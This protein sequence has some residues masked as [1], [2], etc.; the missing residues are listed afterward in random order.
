[1]SRDITTHPSPLMVAMR[2]RSTFLSLPTEVRRLIYSF[3]NEPLT[4]HLHCTAPTGSGKRVKFHCRA[5]L[6]RDNSKPRSLSPALLVTVPRV[7][8]QLQVEIQHEFGDEDLD[9]ETIIG[10]S[11]MYFE[12][13]FDM[14]KFGEERVHLMGL[15]KRLRVCIDGVDGR[16]RLEPEE[17]K[18]FG[19]HR[20][21]VAEYFYGGPRMHGDDFDQL[22]TY[23]EE[24][25]IPEQ[26]SFRLV[27]G[28]SEKKED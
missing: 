1:M 25:R 15:V 24:G 10:E 20:L 12:T 3:I 23:L 16:G 19:F 17:L 26:S 28:E 21:M 27:R 18:D 9:A 14:R 6:A 7:C 11:V 5:H 22:A 13:L 8:R 2:T 4:L